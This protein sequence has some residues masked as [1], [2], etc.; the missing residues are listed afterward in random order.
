MK[1]QKLNVSSPRIAEWLDATSWADSLNWEDLVTLAP[2]L[3]A[4]ECKKGTVI[5]KEGDLR[6]LMA[7][8]VD[9]TVE[10]LKTNETMKKKVLAKVRS[11]Q[12]IGEMSLID[13]Q[14]K[15]AEVK[16]AMQ[17][18]FLLL[19]KPSFESMAEE[20]PKLAV[21]VLHR[22]SSLISQRLR[23]ASGRLVDLT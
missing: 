2:Y 5:F 19:S 22:I 8:L 11:P 12:T 14:P 18:T 1:P 21:K 20:H 17:C 4:Y 15:S 13:G 23:L 16:A 3:D 6:K 10:I 7:I 9:G